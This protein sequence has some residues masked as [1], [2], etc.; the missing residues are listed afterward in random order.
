MP[1]ITEIKSG[2]IVQ[3]VGQV[4]TSFAHPSIEGGKRLYL[5]G[6][7]LQGE[8]L[9]IA[10]AVDNS[11]LVPILGGGSVQLTN[12]NNSGT[13]T[14]TTIRTSSLN[15]AG[16]LVE[17]DENGYPVVTGDDGYYDIVS[18]ADKIK[19]IAGGDGVG[20][21]MQ[22]RMKFNARIFAVTLLRVTLV[23]SNPLILAGNDVPSY[24][25]VFNFGRIVVS[26]EDVDAATTG[27][28]ISNS[29]TTA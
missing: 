17:V 15:A 24:Q 12:N 20:G 18:V 10:Q 8:F 28:D 2:H 5:G 27:D 4:E 3:N 7:R 22:F 14:F 11:V 13:V 25:T 9:N 19:T 1:A 29:L 23:R 16:E 6:F 21:S 26:G